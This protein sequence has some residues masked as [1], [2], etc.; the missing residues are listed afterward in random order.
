[1]NRWV[2]PP[3]VVHQDV[4]IIVRDGRLCGRVAIFS[5]SCTSNGRMRISGSE[6]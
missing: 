3:K 5:I 4:D 1:M 2:Q 6:G